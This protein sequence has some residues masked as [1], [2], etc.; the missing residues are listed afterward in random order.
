M[1]GADKKLLWYMEKGDLFNEAKEKA[2]FGKIEY[3]DEYS[4]QPYRA[5]PSV[6]PPTL[7]I[8]FF[9][10]TIKQKLIIS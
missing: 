2:G 8:D 6:R 5:C 7:C 9:A 1:P 3:E 10:L 4:V